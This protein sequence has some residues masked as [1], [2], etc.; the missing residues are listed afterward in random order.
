MMGDTYSLIWFRGEPYVEFSTEES[1][2]STQATKL[3]R[4]Q[5]K[6]LEEQEQIHCANQRRFL[7]Q[8]AETE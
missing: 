7:K 4:E 1:G 5:Y 3:T 8:I 6:E 2:W